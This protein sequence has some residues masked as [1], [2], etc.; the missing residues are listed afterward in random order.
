MGSA[1]R[2][3]TITLALVIAATASACTTTSRTAAPA[4]PSTTNSSAAPRTSPTTIATVRTPRSLVTWPAG[5]PGAA[6]V[7]LN[8]DQFDPAAEARRHRVIA[9]N[10]WEYGLIP[11]IRAANPD[12]IVL[13]YKDLSSTRSYPGAVDGGG[14][15]RVLPAGVGY[16]AAD[17]THP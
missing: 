4:R 10:S 1:G 16:V 11:Q 12:T 2:V 5:R 13:A 3:P 6:A 8:G 14:G 17:T 15:A 9:L 7:R